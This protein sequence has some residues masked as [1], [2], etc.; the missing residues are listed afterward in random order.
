MVW[1]RLGFHCRVNGTSWRG[2]T[3]RMTVWVWAAASDGISKIQSMSRW[4]AQRMA[5]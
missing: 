1:T 3:G 2:A 4:L 5:A